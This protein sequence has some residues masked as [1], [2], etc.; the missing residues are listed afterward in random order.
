MSKSKRYIRQ[1]LEMHATFDIEPGMTIWH[2]T[3]KEYQEEYKKSV[4]IRKTKEEIEAEIREKERLKK[5]REKEARDREEQREKELKKLKTKNYDMDL[6][7]KIRYYEPLKEPEINYGVNIVLHIPIQMN[8]RGAMKVH[9][10]KSDI[11]ALHSNLDRFR[12][13]GNDKYKGE[14]VIS[15]NGF[16]DDNKEQKDKLKWLNECVQDKNIGNWHITI[17]QR[18][19]Y[20][21][22]W[23]GFYDVWIKYKIL[24]CPYYATLECDQQL[25]KDWYE[26]CDRIM[27]EHP[28][29]GFVGQAPDKNLVKR[30]RQ[31]YR[32][33]ER[34]WVN[35]STM[36]HSRGGFYFCRKELLEAIDKKYGHFTFSMGCDNSI[37]GVACGEIAFSSKT[38][39]LGFSYATI[40]PNRV[41]PQW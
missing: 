14:L 26:E 1:F 9:R 29:H 12:E 28:G 39:H 32:L 19:N 30:L 17:F 5:L 25:T 18:P 8:S 22:Q 3:P 27:R 40:D 20:G 31:Q 7:D 24:E 34:L 11:D 21:Y 15:I 36:Q 13:Q 10:Q 2:D 33:T 41:A 4:K 23:G 37:D 16:I 35:H 38:R 6:L